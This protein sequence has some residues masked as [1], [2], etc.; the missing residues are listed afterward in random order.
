MLGPEEPATWKP[1]PREAGVKHW[2]VGVNPLQT[3]DFR[4]F[5][6]G[7]QLFLR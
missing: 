3:R 4:C 5:V 2:V 6:G 1:I 7:A